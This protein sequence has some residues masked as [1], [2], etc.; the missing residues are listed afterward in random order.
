[1]LMVK[2]FILMLCVISTDYLSDFIWYCINSNGYYQMLI[3]LCLHV[4]DDNCGYVDMM[5]A[6]IPFW[7]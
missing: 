4:V 2:G 6:V 3:D 5:M 7:D 1:M